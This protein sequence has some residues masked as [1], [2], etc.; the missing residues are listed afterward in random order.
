M[1]YKQ[2]LLKIGTRAESSEF[3]R[4]LM[5]LKG[6]K[7]ERNLQEHG[8]LA[9]PLQNGEGREGRICSGKEERRKRPLTDVRWR[10]VD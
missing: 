9:P 6:K 1:P 5:R 3:K 8:G 2:L 4:K 7:K 10:K